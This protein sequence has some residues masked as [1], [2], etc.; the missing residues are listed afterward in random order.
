MFVF[1]FCL[2]DSFCV[3]RRRSTGVRWQ[4]LAAQQLTIISADQSYEAEREADLIEDE[5]CNKGGNAGT[6]SPSVPASDTASALNASCLVHSAG[7][8]QTVRGRAQVRGSGRPCE[9][10]Y[11]GGR[12]GSLCALG[13]NTHAQESR[14]QHQPGGNGAAGGGAAPLARGAAAH[15]TR[16]PPPGGVN[17]PHGPHTQPPAFP[18][19]R[20]HPPRP[21][22]ATP[23]G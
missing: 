3:P 18:G 11:Q 17:T 20:R 1:F 21:P 16:P 9:R 14:P 10:Q 4:L 23:H 19:L 7:P 15:H 8:L 13:T 5:R 22:A 6:F 2:V 12:R